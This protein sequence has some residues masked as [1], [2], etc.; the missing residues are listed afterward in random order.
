MNK[1]SR[2]VLA[3]LFLIAGLPAVAAK[4]KVP[5]LDQNFTPAQLQEDLKVLRDAMEQVHPALYL[6]SPKA[7]F[8]TLFDKT[9]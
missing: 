1:T 9:S 6:Y 7:E 4:R 3:F 2:A 5:T 8:D